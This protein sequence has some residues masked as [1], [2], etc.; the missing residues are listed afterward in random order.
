MEIIESLVISMELLTKPMLN[1][2]TNLTYTT[3]TS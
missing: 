1:G 2:E 3:V